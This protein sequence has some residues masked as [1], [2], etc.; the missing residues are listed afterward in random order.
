MNMYTFKQFSLLLFS[1]ILILSMGS[2][3]SCKGPTGSEGPQGEVGPIGPAGEDG[4][5]IHAGSGE[6]DSEVGAIGDYYLNQNSGELYGPKNDNG[7]G[8]PISLQSP[9]G[10]DGQ[11]GEDGSQIYSG[12][13]A[14]GASQ[15]SPGDYYLNTATFDLYGP[16]TDSG[17]GS[18]INLKGTANVMYSSWI[19]IEGGAGEWTAK[20]LA[21]D[22]LR[23]HD[24]AANSLNEEI[25]NKGVVNVY[26]DFRDL[27]TNLNHIYALPMSDL[28]G[29]GG[30]FYFMYNDQNIRIAYFDEN[31]PQTD[32]GDLNVDTKFRYVIIPGGVAAKSKLSKEQIKSMSYAEVKSR[33]GIRN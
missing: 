21:T 18:P 12:T 16:K 22:S 32:P 26:A 31:S 33:F 2:F 9:P 13:S 28:P 7:W 25:V 27:S 6:P 1:S 8:T 19:T 24:I 3:I 29:I 10:A 23:Y 5:V 4:S 30:S 11:D 20:E 15:G 14:P 17:W